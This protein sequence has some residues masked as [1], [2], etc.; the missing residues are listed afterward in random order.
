MGGGRGLPPGARRYSS[1]SGHSFD[2]ELA[3]AGASEGTR[4]VMTGARHA[5]PATGFMPVDVMGDLV[6]THLDPFVQF[7][8]NED[9]SVNTT[10]YVFQVLGGAMSLLGLPGELLDH[11][12]AIV[13]S[14]FAQASE[15]PAATLLD[16][17]VGMPHAHNHPPS[18]IPPAPP[19]PLPSLGNLMLSG[20]VTV[21]I[22]GLPAARAGDVGLALTCGSFA[23]MFMVVTGS[24]SV[25]IGG[26][27]AARMGDL[28]IHCN[29]I[30]SKIL[31]FS[32]G[33]AILGALGGAVGVGAAA[34]GGNAV[35]AVAAGL[36]A[37]ADVAV[38]AARATVGMDPDIPPMVMGAILTGTPSVMIGGL[39]I[40]PADTLMGIFKGELDLE[41]AGLRRPRAD[42]AEADPQ[43][44]RRTQSG[45]C[46]C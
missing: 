33:A 3:A 10:A 30:L 45:A 38:E 37:A 18:L 19:V 28:T 13:L 27:R 41:A 4:E 34:A 46:E 15:M 22:S 24:S 11:G 26:N 23:P 1:P 29:P 16:L 32:A 39:P 14:P 5:I 9:G 44:P 43:R 42:G 20:A 40:P 35:A 17:H 7:P 31:K 8:Q 25:F 6:N 36:Q 12:V 21:T 2:Q